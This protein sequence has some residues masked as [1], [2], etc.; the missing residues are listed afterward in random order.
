M[1]D[2]DDDEDEDEDDEDSDGPYS[3]GGVFVF[4]GRV[5]DCVIVSNRASLGGGVFIAGDDHLAVDGRVERCE[6]SR[7]R[8][9]G[10]GGGVAIMDGGVVIN[11]LIEFN[12]AFGGGGVVIEDDGVVA[13][14]LILHN[15]S[16]SE[17]EFDGSGVLML[18]GGLVVNC[19][20]LF[21]YATSGGGAVRGIGD[22][23]DPSVPGGALVNSIV[24]GSVGTNV[25]V[26]SLGLVENSCAPELTAGVDGNLNS[27]PL[28]A[29]PNEGD[30][31]LHPTS[32]CIDAGQNMDW[33]D[34]ETD[35]DGNPRIYNAVVD[36]GAFEYT[37]VPA[38]LQV[39]PEVRLVGF[40]GGTV[41]FAVGNGGGDVMA[42]E[43]ET[44]APWL[45]VLSGGIGW[46]SGTVLISVEPNLGEASRSGI[47]TVTAPAA[48]NSPV[49]VAVV[50][51][52]RPA[53]GRVVGWGSHGGAEIQIPDG[54]GDATAVAGG[55]AHSIA[56]LVDGTVTAWGTNSHGQTDVPA[57][58]SNVVAISA[59]SHHN[60]AVRSDGT[61]A[62]W[63]QGSGS[64][65]E[66]IPVW[67]SN[68][69]AV[70]AGYDFSMALLGDGQ[71]VAWG[72]NDCGQTDVP[73][74]LSG[75]K[76]IAAGHLHGVALR[77]NG[78]V[79]AWGWNN[80]GQCDV[81]AGLSNVVAIAAGERH[82]MA[83]KADGT[84]AAWGENSYGQTNV[85]PGLAN[86]VAIA[87]KDMLSMALRADGTVAAWGQNTQGQTNV[88]AGLQAVVGIGAGGYS[89]LALVGP[90]LAVSPTNLAE[91]AAG[92]ATEF[93]VTNSGGGTLTYEAETATPW[94]SI[95]SG[96]TGSAPGTVGLT[97]QA[98]VGSGART[99]TVTVTS[100]D[101]GAG[102]P[103]VV[104]VLQ[105]GASV[106]AAFA[107]GPLSGTAPLTVSFTNQSAGEPTGWTWYFGD[108]TYDG[109]WVE[110]TSGASWA[111]RN[112][113]AMVALNNGNL[114]LMGGFGG[115]SVFRSADRGE[116][117]SQAY[118]SSA[119]WLARYGHAAVALPG[120]VVVAMGGTVSGTEANDVWRSADGGYTWDEAVASADWS[121]RTGHAAV[122]LPDGSIV[123]MGG[124]D[125]A[126]R[127]NDVW[128]SE[129]AGATWTQQT[130]AADWAARMTF[131]AVALPDGGLLVLGGSGELGDL[132]DVWH[133]EDAGATWTQQT[134]S[135]GWAARE[136]HAAVA[137]PNGVVLV[138]G[139][140]AGIGRRNDVWSSCDQGATWTLETDEAEWS[141][142]NGHAAAVLPDGGVVVAGGWDGANA[143]D[144]WLLE[145][146]GSNA[147][148]PQHEY[149]EAGVY[150]VTL[151]AYNE[152]GANA[153]TSVDLVSA[154]APVPVLV[155]SPTNRAVSSSAG[156]T[157][158]AVTNAGP[159][160][161]AYAAT[162]A[163]PWLSI[164]NGAAGT[165]VGVVTVGIA[166]NGLATARTGVVTVTS[167]GASNSPVFVTVVQ[168]G[169]TSMSPSGGET[170]AS[171][172]PA[173][174]WPATPGATWY[175]ISLNR[176]GQSYMG[177][178]VEGATT[179]TPA[180]DLPPGNYRWWVRSW[181]SAAGH[182]PWSA[183]N[184]FVIE[185]ALP[186][187]P[188][189]S[190]PTGGQAVSNRPTF[191]W[192]MATPA[193]TWFQVE[194][195]RNGQLLPL[196]WVEEQESWTPTNNLP[197]GNYQWRVR[198]WNPDG[199]GAWSTAETFVV[200]A[201]RPTVA[202]TPL[203]PQGTQTM[204]DRR[205][206]F[207]WSAVSNATWYRVYASRD[208]QVAID[209]WVE[210][211][212]YAPPADLPAG[213]YRWWVMGWGP[214]GSG[215]WSAATEF[216]LPLQIPGTLTMTSPQGVQI[217]HDL[218]Y[219]WNK[220][221]VATWYRLWVGR[222]GGAVLHDRWYELS[223]TG[224]ASVNP[225]A[226]YP[227]AA[228]PAPSQPV[229]TI[230]NAEPTFRWNGGN[231]EW[232]VRGWGPDGNGPWAGPM[233]FSVPYAP[234][235]WC[236]VYVSRGNTVVLNQWTQAAELAAP[237]PLQTGAHSWWLGV[238]DAPTGRTIWS[239]RVD[240]VVP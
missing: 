6:I 131:A 200:P 32:P 159:G 128:R 30:Y 22:E 211:T 130:A 81:P 11:S 79:A 202:P 224:E 112:G 173:F 27:D 57:G 104:T 55:Y 103:A 121:A 180:N 165:N 93:D 145:T 15:A 142:R 89:G 17:D 23:D 199:F 170:V 39:A 172:R 96:A 69:V 137:L 183:A 143:N 210:A 212:I 193:A 129:D 240:F 34:E 119:P 226:A 41:E 139:G 136:G 174:S 220:D 233:A 153:H 230:A 51:G 19:T 214:D 191:T 177:P 46:D 14:C 182:G 99:G 94:I 113:H 56:L 37:L 181:S 61:A 234:G 152:L 101:A 87:A 171:R 235:T 97:L 133:S 122:A 62:V 44:A 216:V 100:A 70:A 158:F 163:T 218:N 168:A 187:T 48:S 59:G 238:W 201:I 164:S 223:G 205:P 227:N 236:R 150:S 86:V 196:Q 75:V 25:A 149:A 144:V 151:F 10:F 63:G 111:A 157:T 228:K 192:M 232:F 154:A 107:A 169:S 68:V 12:H 118:D 125:G 135:A 146:A 72:A 28:F 215:P 91:N 43:A 90:V 123:L 195:T 134:A 178:W 198:G 204:G 47:V 50:Q 208:G 161:M 84:V 7:N 53:A 92:G 49:E 80:S 190:F 231:C 16:M 115:N 197:L 207:S 5:V 31:R 24:W 184:D 188:T 217:S 132:N 66:I 20:I 85:P 239:D 95:S 60:L 67:L 175:Q 35:L 148:N 108:E 120:S 78:T 45:Q 221:P 160:V 179:W 71:V 162:T 9:E 140:S 176:N 155:V 116:N 64:G 21:N 124:W 156:T 52:G 185:A 73:L 4:G 219:V 88:P 203:Y 74:G 76:A 18:E 225:G 8:A 82:T 33:M 166:S 206:E 209:R 126:N 29:D 110:M 109:E 213:T 38:V 102:S 138:L 83:L 141:A 222:V 98:N 54:L 13:N 194:L 65:E 36:M 77:A 229:G 42:Y 114:V 167:A 105:A 58:L 237:A 40:V 117:W 1:D 106:Q 2:D 26:G 186:A 189:P 147:E 3:G 127:L